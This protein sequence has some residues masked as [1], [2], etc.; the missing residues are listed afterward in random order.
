MSKTKFFLT[1]SGYQLTW[2][3][4]IFGELLFNS[5]IPGLVFGIIFLL[6]YFIYS[7]NKKRYFNIL[8]L[9]SIPGY[10][11]DTVLIYLNVYEFKTSFSLGYLPIW[12]VILWLSFATL[13]D[14]VFVFLSRYK[15]IAI[16]LSA[17]LGPL[18]Y[19]SGSPLGLIKINQFYIFF[20][21]MI[22]FWIALM[23][24]YLN[25][26]LKKIKLN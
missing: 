12:M 18:T 26:V 7:D 22:I 1:L 9:I 16:I 24:Y 20:I 5:F 6:L 21:S 13:F 17:I 19:Y 15:L 8:L 3:L 2:L 4:C 11:F 14:K 23:I 10:F 25:Y